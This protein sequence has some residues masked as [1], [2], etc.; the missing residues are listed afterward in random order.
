MSLET[1]ILFPFLRRAEDVKNRHDLRSKWCLFL[2]PQT[3]AA[4]KP[5]SLA[6]FLALVFAGL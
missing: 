6:T 5:A 2:F 4:D 1:A 3:L